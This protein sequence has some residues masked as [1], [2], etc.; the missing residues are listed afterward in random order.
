VRI[1]QTISTS[2]GDD[3]QT[4]QLYSNYFSSSTHRWHR[5]STNRLCASRMQKFRSTWCA[6]LPYVIFT[7]NVF[8][9]VYAGLQYYSARGTAVS[10]MVAPTLRRKRASRMTARTV[11]GS[12]SISLRVAH[13]KSFVLPP[14]VFVIN[15]L[16]CMRTYTA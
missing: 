7:P 9:Q 12:W 13:C 14:L 15:L 5:C 3:E 10:E 16:Y 11:L 1:P 8:F 4:G 6:F 2:Y